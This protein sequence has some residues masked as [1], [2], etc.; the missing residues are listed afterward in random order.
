[1]RK[2]G[3]AVIQTIGLLFMTMFTG[4]FAIDAG[5]YFTMHRGMQNAADA[6]A[7][8]AASELYRYAAGS[9]S[10]DISLR[11]ASSRSAAQDLSNDNMNYELDT[12]DIEFGYV[13]PT[14][15]DYNAD[16][17]TDPTTNTEF[18]ATGGYNAVRTTVKAAEGEANGPISTVFSKLLGINDVDSYAQAVAIYGGGINSSGGLRPIYMCETA[19]DMA[20]SNY[21]D[22]STP[23][24]TFYGD[25]LEV[26]GTSVDAASSCGNLGPGNWGLADFDGGGGGAQQ[27]NDVLLNGWNG[28]VTLGDSY[29]PK[30]GNALNSSD[31]ELT[32]LRDNG[33]IISVPLYS[34]TTGNGN[35]AT[36][37]VSKIVG[38]KITDFKTN[39]NNTYI[40]GH[41]QKAICH[42]NCAL[43]STFPGGGNTKLFMVH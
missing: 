38:F 18:S 35:N 33:T 5:L 42:S 9:T 13:D 28:T 11:L 21:G 37:K 36:F 41:F 8:A 29:G 32:T 24:V 30:P 12:A 40:T 4:A 26:D 31:P 43:G 1:M 27:F 39:G 3:Q 6:A 15:K 25:T 17:F 7:L 2:R 14:T 16:T 23:E 22:P 10:E 19:F 34:E 20:T